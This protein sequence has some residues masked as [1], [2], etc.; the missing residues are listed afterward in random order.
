MLS[1]RAVGNVLA[2][3]PGEVGER[4]AVEEFKNHGD[5]ALG[6]RS[7]GRVGLDMGI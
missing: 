3:L 5:V 6:G 2:Q 4:L 1:H 7:V